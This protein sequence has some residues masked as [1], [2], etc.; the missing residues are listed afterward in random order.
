LKLKNTREMS[1]RKEKK[2]EEISK[3]DELKREKDKLFKILN[4]SMGNLK[5]MNKK[6]FNLTFQKC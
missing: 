6:I 5:V 3:V 1:N 4:I 2:Y